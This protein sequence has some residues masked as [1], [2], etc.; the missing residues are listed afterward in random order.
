VYIRAPV[1]ECARMCVRVCDGYSEAS[2]SW[3]SVSLTLLC[4]LLI[5]ACNGAIN[6]SA[7]SP[8]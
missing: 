5:A 3:S 7:V 6:T 1:R 4:K 2:F 8:L